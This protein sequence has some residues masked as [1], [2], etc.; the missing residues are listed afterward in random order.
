[1]HWVH[2]II[3]SDFCRKYTQSP[4]YAVGFSLGG[5]VL[6]KYLAEPGRQHG[7]AN[8]NGSSA[9]PAPYPPAVPCHNCA[10]NH[11]QAAAAQRCGRTDGPPPLEDTSPQVR[12]QA[13]VDTSAALGNAC[14]SPVRPSFKARPSAEVSALPH[15]PQGPS[16]PEPPSQ[17]SVFKAEPPLTTPPPFSPLHSA[18][19]GTGPAERPTSEAEERGAVAAGDDDSRVEKAAVSEASSSED[20]NG[21]TVWGP[22]G[23]PSFPPLA[24]VPYPLSQ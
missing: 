18:F 7:K 10:K 24:R 14:S 17:V 16:H 8:S 1:M 12:S 15:R 11:P 2:A 20:A 6:T 3:V 13:S 22:A 21:S 23:A 4:L 9:M 5:V 19:Q